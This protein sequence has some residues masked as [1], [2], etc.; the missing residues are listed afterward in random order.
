MVCERSVRP[1][2]QGDGEF[3]ETI[4]VIECTY[5]PYQY[6][7]KVHNSSQLHQQHTSACQEQP[8]TTPYSSHSSKFSMVCDE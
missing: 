5:I 7:R 2:C 1:G 6:F 8:T 4:L 3:V